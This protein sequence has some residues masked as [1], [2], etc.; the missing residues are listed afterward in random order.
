MGLDLVR[1]LVGEEYV[2]GIGADFEAR[3]DNSPRS[4]LPMIRRGGDQMSIGAPFDGAD[5]WSRELA[6]WSPAIQSADMDILPDKLIADARARD[7]LRN[8]AYVSSGEHLHKDNI[9]GGMYWLN[10]KPNLRILGKSKDDTWEQEFQEEVEAKFTL[11][12]ESLSNWIDA[13]RMNSFTGLIRLGV[14]V[15]VA[16]GELLASAE[17]IREQPRPYK[18]AVQF[19]DLDRLQNPM[20]TNDG[21]DLRGGIE[22]NSFGAPLAYHIRMAHPT[23]WQDPDAWRSKRVPIRTRWGRMQMIHIVEQQRVDQTRGIAEMVAA[24]EEMKITKKFRKIVLQNAVVN[25]TY[26]ASIESELPSEAAF[27]AL[28]AGNMAD[29]AT[30]IT[31]YTS[32][33]LS[34]IAQYIGNSK[35]MHIDGVKIPH[36]FPGTKLQLRPAGQGGP[37]GTDFETSLLRYIAANL[38][39]SYEQLSRDYSKTNYSSIRAAMTE[40]W[41]FMQARKRAVADRFA[42]HIYRLWFEE[43]WNAGDIETAKGGPDLYD[44]LNWDA[45]TQCEWIGAS[46]GQIDELKETQ[47][48]TLR[49][50]YNLSTH[51]DELARLGKDWRTVFAQKA[52]EKKMMDDLDIALALA[53][54]DSAQNAITG[55]TRESNAKGEPSDGSDK[56]DS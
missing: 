6:S 11:Y 13:S 38:G 4:N 9:V 20:G 41:K 2:Q 53:P 36:L 15:F 25:A 44:G 47:A 43:A 21:P 54:E 56:A 46:K 24:L 55:D 52:R 5:R 1:E 35:N 31:N 26:A 29:S 14:G 3:P 33:Y 39:V 18:T 23:D 48:A 17:W 19:I 49:L 16:A 12:A 45:Y 34:A 42:G 27:A 10:A 50:K 8:D 51:E 30:A 37:L 40:T 22:R 32:G 7:M 28:G